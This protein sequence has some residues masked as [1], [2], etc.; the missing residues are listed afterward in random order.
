MRTPARRLPNGRTRW[1][2]GERPGPVDCVPARVIAK[3][4]ATLPSGAE[5]VVWIAIAAVIPSLC[6]IIRR[7]RLESRDEFLNQ[8]EREAEVRKN[9][10]D[11]K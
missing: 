7:T 10:P 6:L 8:A 1:P 9:D 4:G 3:N 2:Q 11:M 5:A